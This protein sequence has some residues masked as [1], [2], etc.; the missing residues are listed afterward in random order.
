MYVD[1]DLASFGAGLGEFLLRLRNQE[2]WTWNIVVQLI[3]D[4]LDV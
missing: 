3:V 4:D 1:G 2:D